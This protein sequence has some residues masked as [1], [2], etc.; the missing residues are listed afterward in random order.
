MCN[1][2][3]RADVCLASELGEG[4]K[5]PRLDSVNVEGRVSGPLK[6]CVGALFTRKKFSV[7]APE[8]Q[9]RDGLPD[10]ENNA[11]FQDAPDRL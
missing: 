11:A 1:G 4:R 5:Q 10:V 8:R 2:N 9:L 6:A 3:N 7:A